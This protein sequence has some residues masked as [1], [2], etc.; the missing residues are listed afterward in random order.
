MQIDINDKIFNDIKKYCEIN[1]LDYNVLINKLLKQSFTILKYGEKPLGCINI[2]L[3]KDNDNL[4]HT[5]KIDP[6]TKD[7]QDK[8]EDNIINSNNSTKRRRLL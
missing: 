5:N 6:N 4:M 3:N 2:N 7:K 8:I 1:D